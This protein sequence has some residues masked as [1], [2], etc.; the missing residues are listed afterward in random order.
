MDG[1]HDRH[2]RGVAGS[3]FGILDF[4]FRIVKETG[5]SHPAFTRMDIW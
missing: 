5:P 1:G 3:R 2:G 4:D